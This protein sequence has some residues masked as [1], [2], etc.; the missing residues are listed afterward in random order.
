MSDVKKTDANE[1]FS[2]CRIR[3]KMDKNKITAIY[4]FINPAWNNEIRRL[5]GESQ[6]K[7]FY[8][9]SVCIC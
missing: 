8:S 5:K 1:Y 3:K 6:V 9:I 2:K 7:I 4:A